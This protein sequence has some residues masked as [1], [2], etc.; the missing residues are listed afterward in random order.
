[1]PLYLLFVSGIFATQFKL[2]IDTHAFNVVLYIFLP[3]DDIH[4]AKRINYCMRLHICK[5]CFKD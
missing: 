3:V 4:L 2:I 1:M 5:K